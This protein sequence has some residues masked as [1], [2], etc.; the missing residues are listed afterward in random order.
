[1]SF[2]SAGGA[3]CAG[4]LRAGP[5]VKRGRGLLSEEVGRKLRER[6]FY[7]SLVSE[8]AGTVLIA[9]PRKYR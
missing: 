6:V 1:M 5:V 2:F 3:Q 8:L 9:A 4:P 7:R